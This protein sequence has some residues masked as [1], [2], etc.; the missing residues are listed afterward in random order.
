MAKSSPKPATPV[1]PPQIFSATL[2]RMGEVVK[3][4][5]LTLPQAVAERQQ[6][7]DVVV[8][9]VRVAANLQV[10]Q[11][12]ESQATGGPCVF[13]AAHRSAGPHTLAH[14]QP[15]IRGLAGHTFLEAPPKRT[16]R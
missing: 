11:Q 2:G 5:V 15:R 10:A 16:A 9:G 4:R 14:F 13:H 1:R 7:G 12:I 8:C 3:G 6:G